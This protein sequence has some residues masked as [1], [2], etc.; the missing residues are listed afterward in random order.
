[1]KDYKNGI[2]EPKNTI[3]VHQTQLDTGQTMPYDAGK[4]RD[5]TIHE[6]TMLN[7]LV[8]FDMSKKRTF[9]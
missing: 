1:M 5:T 7:S 9:T 2:L 8:S 3:T 6:P 4:S